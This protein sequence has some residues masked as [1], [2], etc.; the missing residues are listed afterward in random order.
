MKENP[1]NAKLLR[2]LQAMRK[3]WRIAWLSVLAKIY[4][5][6]L[7]QLSPSYIYRSEGYVL[8]EN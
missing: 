6:D 8:G 4:M 7:F 5:C 3:K 2:A 1:A